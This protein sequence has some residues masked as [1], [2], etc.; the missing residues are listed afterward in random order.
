MKE[1]II[2]ELKT[3]YAKLGLSNEVF[4]GVASLLEKTVTEESA[5][6]TAVSGDDV[7]TMLTTIQ[8]QTDSWK[9]KF[10][11]ER[12]KLADYK[13]S[14]P[15]D[16]DEGAKGGKGGEGKKTEDE[17]AVMKKLEELT[18]RLDKAENEKKQA[19]MLASVKAALKS[20]G[21]SNEKVLDLVL[22]GSPIAES[23]TEEDAVTR[24][25]S[26][27]NATVKDL[28]GDG[29]IPPAGG[30]GGGTGGADQATI[31]RRKAWIDQHR[32]EDSGEGKK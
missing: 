28:Y 7:R 15:D 14:H 30:G 12:K 22:K 27:Y 8:G 6:A 9:N 21:C 20:G 16:D 13:E 31:A 19:V 29:A 4:D 25:T 26:E 3:V 5:I 10:Y 11:D 23:E 1:K 32:G 2:A 17:S 18:A 24:L